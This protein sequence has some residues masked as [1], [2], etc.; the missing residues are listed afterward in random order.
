[1]AKQNVHP[2]IVEFKKFVKKHPTLIAEVRNGKKTWQEIYEDWYLL[3]EDDASWKKY[4]GTEEKNENKKG[5][6]SDIMNKVL[7]SIKNVNMNDVQQQISNVGS[8]ITTIQQVIHQFKGDGQQSGAGQSKD[9]QK[10][11]QNHPFAFRKD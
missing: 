4:S 7:T 5:S 1:M 2:T 9:A 10:R 8:A 3:G 6:K 11:Q